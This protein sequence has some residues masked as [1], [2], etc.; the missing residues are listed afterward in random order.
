M[1]KLWLLG[2]DA[3]I[4]NSGSEKHDVKKDVPCGLNNVWEGQRNIQLLE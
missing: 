1:L 2:E 4:L 3:P